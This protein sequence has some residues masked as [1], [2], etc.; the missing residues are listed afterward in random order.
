L[1]INIGQKSLYRSAISKANPSDQAKPNAT[2]NPDRAAVRRNG[3][4]HCVGN[5]SITSGTAICIFEKHHRRG[6]MVKLESQLAPE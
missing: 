5:K 6:V 2:E 4:K 1:S 3:I